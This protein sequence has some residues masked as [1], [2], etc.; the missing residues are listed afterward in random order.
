MD[1]GG[2]SGA[3]TFHL[4]RDAKDVNHFVSFGSWDTMET[5]QDWSNDN[6]FSKLYGRCVELCDEVD[7]GPFTLAAGRRAE[8]RS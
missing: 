7:S 6:T 1:S 4:L 2:G 8:R 5:M 3:R